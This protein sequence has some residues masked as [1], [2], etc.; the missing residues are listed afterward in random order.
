MEEAVQLLKDVLP[1]SSC[2]VCPWGEKGAA[3]KHPMGNAFSVSSF[4]P[5]SG[6]KVKGLDK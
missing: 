2:V 4:P 5:P 1:T 3:A 6:N